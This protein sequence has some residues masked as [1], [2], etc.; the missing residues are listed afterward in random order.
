MVVFDA[1]DDEF[2]IQH[3]GTPR[4][5][6]RYPWG[7][8]KDPYQS[9]RSFRGHVQSLRD[10]GMSDTEIA[11]GM[12]MTTTAFRARLSNARAE[13]RAGDTA[14]AIKLK[15]KG[16]STT[17]IGQRMGLSE[18][19]VRSLLDPARKERASRL[20]N[21]INALANAVSETR[22]I[23]IG[24]GT[25]IALG[26]SDQMKR[27]AVA[28]LKDRGYSVHTFRTPQMGTGL[29]TTMN[30]LAPPGTSFQEVVQNKNRITAVGAHSDDNGASFISIEP[31][32]SID[33]DRVSV[34]Y[35]EDGG[36]E[37]DGTIEIRR[38]VDDLSLGA[39]NY[40]QVRIKVGDK[41]YLKGMAVY[42]DDI[43]DGYDI[44]FNTN[45]HAGTPKLGDKDNT[46]LKTVK[47]DET[48]PFGA[49]IKSEDELILAQ[50]YYTDSEGNKKQSAINIVKEEGN[51]STQQRNL[52]SQ[53]LSKQTPAMAKKQL[54]LAYD[55][56]LREFN[57][58]NSLTNPSVKK[59]L[60]AEFA[61]DC[62][63]KA[64]HLKAAALPRSGWNVILPID[65]LSSNEIYA[66]NYRNGE[67][68][69][70][71][72]YPHAGR[73]EIPVL[74]VNN[75]NPDGDKVITK[76]ARDAVGINSVV[77]Q[78]LSGADFDGDTVLVIPTKGTGL[79][80]SPP[81]KDLK[82]FDPSEAYAMPKGVSNGMTDRA[83]QTEMGKISNLITDMTVMGASEEEIARAVKHSMVVIDAVKHNLNYKQ[84]AIDNGI[85][86]LKRKYQGSANAGAATLISRAK[87]KRYVNTRKEYIDPETGEKRYKYT[88]ETYVDKKTGATKY[89]QT[90][91]TAMAE[92]KDARTL[93]SGT[94]IENIYADYAN[95]MKAM[96]NDARKEYMATKPIPYSPS[97]KRTYAEEV[98]SL[99]SKL[100]VAR[101]NSPRER[102]A[103][104]IANEIV[105]GKKYDNPDMSKDELRKV[106]SQALNTARARTG[107]HKDRINISDREWEAIQA[108]AISS[109]K[110]DQILSNSDPD[111][112]RSLAMP[113]E[114]R[115]LTDAQRSRIRSLVNNGATVAEAALALG[116]STSTVSEVLNG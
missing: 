24:P 52:A 53:M 87:S 55:Q 23:D 114:T 58:I 88:D 20:D 78:Q 91:S 9:A 79:K 107:A 109:N 110:L 81:L 8:G 75:N 2:Y 13:Q 105:R 65:S 50:R 89:R 77:A 30:V 116:V 92:T 21:T 27:N 31:P 40:A 37:R 14:M 113:R 18:S 72:R 64:V 99:D 49:T 93:S 85:P 61:E 104:L 12:G 74:K 82:G 59:K 5:S 1:F 29:Y 36:A 84:S 90:T 39:A 3:Y 34:R 28:I 101:A 103:Q 94:Q 7:S 42:S 70:L 22:Y 38:G 63:S 76:K 115:T 4:H 71:I 35:K 33:P 102:Q 48:N 73:F 51:W 108:G 54:D 44:V 96:A 80:S 6:G 45:K 25:E 32:V 26:V 112:V 10:K 67:T 86:E 19:T 83:K 111:R 47:D 62:D 11:R 46:V 100:G 56:S 60:L 98:A 106:K 68:V 15:N 66:P 41:H 17:A 16:Y 43:P 57:E 95:R 69:A 97:A